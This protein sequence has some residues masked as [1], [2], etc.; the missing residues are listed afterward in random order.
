MNKL[1][2]FLSFCIITLALQG[3]GLINNGATISVNSAY[4]TIYGANGHFLNSDN[5]TYTGTV[6]LKG[7]IDLDGNWTNN[8]AGNVM[9]S[10]SNGTVIMNGNIQQ[11][12]KGNTAT[13]FYNL[14]FANTYGTS[15]HISMEVSTN[16]LHDLTLP[17][18]NNI[19]CTDTAITLALGKDA[20]NTGELKPNDGSNY[21]G[22]YLIGGS[23]KRWYAAATNSN[24]TGLFPLGVMDGATL[25]NRYIKVEY[26]TAP[27]TGGTLRTY[28]KADPMLWNTAWLGAGSP[29][30][31]PSV[32]GCAGF[33]ITSLCDEGYW[34]ANAR[35]G[36]TG[37]AYKISLRGDGLPNATYSSCYLTALKASY[38]NP[39]LEGDWGVNGTHVAPTGGLANPLVVRTGATGFSKW[40]L[41]GGGEPYPLPV[42]LL[43][44]K[45]RCVTN[46]VKIEWTTASE[47]NNN[48]FNIERSYD[49]TNWT[50]IAQIPGSGNSNQITNYSYIDEIAANATTYYRLKQTDFDGAYE[51]FAPT[52]I[53]CNND[54]ENMIIAV[55]PNPFKEIINIEI[56]NF[57]FPQAQVRIVDVVGKTIYNESLTTS[58]NYSIS[59]SYDLKTMAAGVYFIEVSARDIK[60]NFK[61]VK[62]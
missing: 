30:Y 36:L 50:V 27:T 40:G 11:K 28:W 19:G 1:I 52:S 49:A 43:E 44:F 6:D 46:G 60:K 62:N 26:T 13:N 18:T 39:G 22:G 25:Y 3:Q 61:I 58:P 9:T 4:V 32:S 2:H 54:S 59:T 31:I 16:V 56:S 48:Y 57:G 24:H 47:T 10:T 33:E 15:P 35:D 41:A 51:Y 29:P 34:Q 14:T 7:T 21:T 17:A 55:Y 5:G 37:G 12:I 38:N 20:S 23:M 53:N 42:E 8:S 45:A